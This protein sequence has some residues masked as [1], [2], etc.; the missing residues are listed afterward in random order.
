VNSTESKPAP[1]RRRRSNRKT[2]GVDET[3]M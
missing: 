1:R 3:T 2:G